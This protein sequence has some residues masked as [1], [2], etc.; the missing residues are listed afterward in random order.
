[1]KGN[2]LFLFV[3]IAVIAGCSQTSSSSFS[4]D[5]KYCQSLKQRI[6]SQ[7][8]AIGTNIKPTAITKT[9]LL[10]RYKDYG[11]TD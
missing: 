4:V 2:L 5:P 1:M 10:Q 3:S 7:D 11:C 8:A 6:N 9:K